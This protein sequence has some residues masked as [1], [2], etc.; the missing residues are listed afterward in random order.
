M[1]KGVL[2]AVGFGVIFL[3]I[4]LYSTRGLSEHR[5]E[6]CVLFGG[7]QVCR[8]AS[9][10]TRDEARRAATDTACAVLARGM[11]ESIAC[12]GQPPAKITWLEE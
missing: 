1:K 8:T 3:A 10:A 12:S 2:I 6:V 9:G 7:Q 4:M 5:V 11:A